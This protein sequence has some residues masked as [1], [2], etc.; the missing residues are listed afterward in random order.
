MLRAQTFISAVF[1]LIS[2]NAF[3][4]NCTSERYLNNIFQ[5]SVSQDVVFGNS[6]AITAVY[7]A[8]NVTVNQAMTM[9]VFFPVGDVLEKRPLV[10]LAFGGG[11]W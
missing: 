3:A 8:E 2:I 1:A 6:P 11:F 4:Q 10:V 7:V 5:S 9:D